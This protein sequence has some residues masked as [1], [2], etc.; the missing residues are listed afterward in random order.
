MEMETEVETEAPAIKALASLFK[1]TQVFLWEDAWVDIP[2]VSSTSDHLESIDKEPTNFYDPVASKIIRS[3]ID[4]TING[5]TVSLEDRELVRQMNDLGLPVSFSTNK[6]RTVTAKERRKSSQLKSLSGHKHIQEQLVEVST[7]S[8]KEKTVQPIACWDSTN[9]DVDCITASSQHDT[10]QCCFAEDERKQH[11]PYGHGDSAGLAAEIFTDVQEQ[12]HEELN[13]VAK[14]CN[15]TSDNMI[16]SIASVNDTEVAVDL[17]PSNAENI[18][19]DA[20]QATC[21]S[22]LEHG[23]ANK[24]PVDIEKLEGYCSE[25]KNPCDD[26]ASKRDW[27]SNTIGSSQPTDAGLLDAF[28]GCN[29][30]SDLGDWRAYWDGF[31]MRNYFYNVRTHESTWI[32]PPGLEYLAY[33]DGAALLG[34]NA[35][36]TENSAPL[37]LTC[38]DVQDACSSV[39]HT[40]LFDEVKNDDSLSGQQKVKYGKEH[41][42]A[43]CMSCLDPPS[44]HNNSVHLDELERKAECFGVKKN[45]DDDLYP[46]TS[47]SSVSTQD[48]GER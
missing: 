44:T 10:S 8:D 40:H 27:I 42:T 24:D 7:V 38:D 5:Y 41:A 23:E 33:S 28:D 29:Q 2:K 11:F 3:D 17:S 36:R 22:G 37:E 43:N 35:D 30:C 6:K 25:A 21:S 20:F 4:S 1:I 12:V 19:E 48:C 39:N 32:P 47:L 16:D 18:L 14:L 34:E 45:S 46:A 26:N 9:T 31:Y 13:G 15:V